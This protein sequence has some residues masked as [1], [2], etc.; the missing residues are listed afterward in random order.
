MGRFIEELLAQCRF[1]LGRFGYDNQPAR[2]LVDAM[3]QP[4]LR[5]VRIKVL[6]IFHMPSH[7][8]DERSREI[9]GTGMHHHSCFLIN[10]HQLVILVDDIQWYIFCHN[11]R[12]VLRTVEHQRNRIA[13]S[14]LVIAL[15]G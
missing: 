15:D 1:G 3:H 6:D 5:V 11:R 7:R 10:H 9:T 2:I 14:H 12:V 4:H 13:R 8:I